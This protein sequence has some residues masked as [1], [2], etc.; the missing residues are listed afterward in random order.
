MFALIAWDGLSIDE[1]GDTNI[2]LV[3]HVTDMLSSPQSP[4]LLSIIQCLA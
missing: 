4:L 3:A 2:Y 1:C